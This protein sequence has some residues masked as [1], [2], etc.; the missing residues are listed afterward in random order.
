MSV[1]ILTK[2]LLVLLGDHLLTASEE[3]GLAG[4]AGILLHTAKVE[5]NAEVGAVN[6]LVATSSN[7]RAIGHSWI[8]AG[9]SV[10][11]T[12]L[13]VNYVRAL[14]E[15]LKKLINKDNRN[16]HVSDLRRDGEDIVI[17]E[18]P[19]LFGHGFT[20][21]FAW[22]DLDTFPRT[23]FPLLTSMHLTAPP[24]LKPVE[25]RTDYT[26]SALAPFLTIANRH[27]GSISLY[28][29]HQS[30]NVHIQIGLSYRGLIAPSKGWND[31]DLADGLAPDI[32][33]YA[34]D[35]PPLPDPEDAEE[36]K[37]EPAGVS[38]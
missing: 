2:D 7:G 14:I 37:Q 3:A 6:C 30:V 27:S 13:P 17:A 11:P 33:V 31:S 8:E 32:G 4:C 12:L 16:E 21:R 34:A 29:V 28:R 19:D 20:Q 10:L 5:E 15:S 9:G 36:S 22:S 35:L 38:S 1:R 25:N 26:A 18:D 24:D 23:V